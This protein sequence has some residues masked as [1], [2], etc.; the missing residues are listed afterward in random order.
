MRTILAHGAWWQEW[1]HL[2]PY[3]PFAAALGI[4][5][6]MGWLHSYWNSRLALAAT[7]IAFLVFGFA[8]DGISEIGHHLGFLGAG[9]FA[10][11]AVSIG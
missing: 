5:A 3:I 6:A 4:G 11:R 2:I 9:F 7:A 8:I 10:G 1:H